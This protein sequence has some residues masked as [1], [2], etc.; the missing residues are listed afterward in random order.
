[1]T[2]ADPRPLIVHVVYRFAV[3]GLENGVVNLINHLPAARWRHAILTLTEVEPLMRA[4]IRRSY[5]E[6]IELR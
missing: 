3:G 4:R 1:M 6:Y 2:A 5:V